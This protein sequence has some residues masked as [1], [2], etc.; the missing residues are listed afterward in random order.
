MPRTATRPTWP[1]PGRDRLALVVDHE[2]VLAELELGAGRGALLRRDRAAHAARLAAV[3]EVDHHH[4]RRMREQARLHL[5][6]PHHPRRRHDAQLRQ[7]V[8]ARRR[9][10]QVDHRTTERVA[11]DAEV[12]HAVADDRVEQSTGIEPLLGKRHH[13]AAP[14][15]DRSKRTRTPVPCMSGGAGSPTGTWSSART[16]SRTSDVSATGASL[17]TFD[18][19]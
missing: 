5:L 10:E 18:A 14:V 11:D 2:R 1:L 3:E 15:E 12:R 9:V 17:V 8:A 16:R 4:L 6:A 13:R 19:M 7:V